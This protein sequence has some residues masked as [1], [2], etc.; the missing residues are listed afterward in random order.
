M[1]DNLYPNT[2]WWYGGKPSEYNPFLH[3]IDDD[4]ND[5]GYP[6]EICNFIFIVVIVL[7]Q[8]W[9][10]VDRFIYVTYVVK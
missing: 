6:E 8:H 7:S 5:S 10:K 2:K 9:F 3:P 1:I 4:D